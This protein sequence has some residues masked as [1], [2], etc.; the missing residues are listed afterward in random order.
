MVSTMKMKRLAWRKAK[1]TKKSKVLTKPAVKTVKKIVKRAIRINEEL[2]CSPNLTIADQAVVA[3]AGLNVGAGLGFTQTTSIVPQI[4]LGTSDGQRIGNIIRPTRLVLKYTVAA[5]EVS[6][7]GGTNPFPAM[8]FLC[9]VLVYS[10]KYATDDYSNNNILDV[11]NAS[12]NLGS[13]PDFWLE[14]YNKKEFNIHYSKQ[15][16]MQP[17]RTTFAGTGYQSDNLANGAKTFVMRKA[18]IK[19][20][21]KFYFNDT[22]GIPTNC[23]MYFSV[24]IC[25]QDGSVVTSTQYR[26]QV[27]AE[28]YLYYRD[29]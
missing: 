11:G 8:P 26:A 2:K 12:N 18:I 23:G 7:A 5:R 17:V 24:A 1:A 15:F 16:L 25:N 28:S 21:K 6:I 10:H 19:V 29:A 14:P 9:R 22:T 13:T 27:N 20:P 4:P 3:G